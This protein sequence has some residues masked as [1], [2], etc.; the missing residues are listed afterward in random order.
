M[1]ER[2]RALEA[3]SV[4]W[5]VRDPD[6]VRA[7]RIG[8]ED[9]SVDALGEVARTLGRR[10]G[11]RRSRWRGWWPADPRSWAIDAGTDRHGGHHD[12]DGGC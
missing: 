5:A 12:E 6:C 9:V 4:D 7:I 2:V 1:D 3:L 11:G 10:L 8:R